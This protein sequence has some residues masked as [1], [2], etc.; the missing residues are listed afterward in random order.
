MNACDIK[1]ALTAK[2]PV[3]S[4]MFIIGS[5][6]KNNMYRE[7]SNRNFVDTLIPDALVPL[8]NKLVVNLQSL[9]FCGRKP[10]LEKCAVFSKNSHDTLSARDVSAKFVTVKNN[11]TFKRDSIVYAVFHSPP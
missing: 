2:P 5:L 4:T 11:I 3:N 10:P 8:C 1:F 9:V 7:V 6:S